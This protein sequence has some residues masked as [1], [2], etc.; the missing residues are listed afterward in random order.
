MS[1]SRTVIDASSPKL[2]KGSS[3]VTIPSGSAL[4]N[5]A[6]INLSSYVGQFVT[7]SCTAAWRPRAAA[8]LTLANA[9]KATAT[10][11][12]MKADTQ[13][14]FQVDAESQYLSVYGDAAGTLTYWKSS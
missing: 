8:T 3:K 11:A 9:T 4:T 2:P 13:Y 12:P 6:T 14:S 1:S 10:N 5:G 7:F